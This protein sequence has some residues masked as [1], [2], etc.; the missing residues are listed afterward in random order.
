MQINQPGALLPPP[1]LVWRKGIPF[2]DLRFHLDKNDNCTVTTDSKRISVSHPYA[3]A[4]QFAVRVRATCRSHDGGLNA[5]MMDPWTR[6]Q[7]ISA[8]EDIME[9]KHSEHFRQ[10]VDAA[11]E[12]RLHS[13]YDVIKNPIDL[14]MIM[15]KLQLPCGDKNGYQFTSEYQEDMQRMFDNCILFFPKADEVEHKSC[16]RLIKYFDKQQD[17]LRIRMI[18]RQRIAVMMETRQFVSLQHPN[19]PR[20]ILTV[21][22]GVCRWYDF[23][24]DNQMYTPWISCA[25]TCWRRCDDQSS[26]LK[27]KEEP[28]LTYGDSCEW[29]P[30]ESDIWRE[31]SQSKWDS[32]RRD[33]GLH[34]VS[35]AQFLD[36][37]LMSIDEAID[38]RGWL[39]GT[40]EPWS[41]SKQAT[42]CVILE[43]LKAAV[44][45]IDIQRYW[46]NTFSRALK[47]MNQLQ[48]TYCLSKYMKRQPLDF[49][50][51]DFEGETSSELEG[52][53][54][55]YPRMVGTSAD[56]DQLQ[57]Q[58]RSFQHASAIEL[59]FSE[60]IAEERLY[61]EV[62]MNDRP[63]RVHFI[64][65]WKDG[66]HGDQPM[67][68]RDIY[69]C[70]CVDACIYLI[71]SRFGIASSLI[72]R[73]DFLIATAS[74]R[75]RL[76]FR[77]VM[78]DLWLR[79][80]FV[81]R[82]N[83]QNEIDSE[84]KETAENP[85]A[86]HAILRENGSPNTS[87]FDLPFFPCLR[88]TFHDP[89]LPTVRNAASDPPTGVAFTP[90]DDAKFYPWPLEDD[91][92]MIEISM[93]QLPLPPRPLMPSNFE[94]SEIAQ[95]DSVA[96]LNNEQ[97]DT[98]H[99]ETTKNEAETCERTQQKIVTS[100]SQ[101]SANFKRYLTGP[102]N[103]EK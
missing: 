60:Q 25:V 10:P 100:Q 48:D 14:S 77:A 98:V 45:G 69:L 39:V 76:L 3:S 21:E 85:A 61:A 94:T 67:P 6:R 28:L 9:N 89:D 65:E 16:K 79:N 24:Y 20:I 59:Y 102:V 31:A 35:N 97:S 58:F 91:V 90:L 47:D 17:K 71:E 88:N 78:P 80:P 81:D 82:R 103:R 64:F 70:R 50:E 87:V 74:S 19:E 53:G 92:A 36:L 42:D 29:D 101:Q 73:S 75:S 66:D 22:A 46:R 62:L 34:D 52:K 57:L 86:P 30:K 93:L 41:Y 44:Q 43:Q 83:L 18:K 32:V 99:L 2:P 33:L 1:E 54:H 72:S 56:D 13:Y 37:L 5:G 4:L 38:V 15:R 96:G 11:S 55:E 49:V 63:C 40:E 51:A 27:W 23:K 95:V 26:Y 8:H 68:H 84:R 12:K 7:Y